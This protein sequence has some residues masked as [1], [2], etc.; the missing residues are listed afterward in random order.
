MVDS[1]EYAAAIKSIWC[2]RCTVNVKQDAQNAVGR[3]VQTEQTLF[4]DEPCRLSY[5][6]I[7]ITD[8][9]SQAARLEQQTVLIIDSALDIPPGS[10]ITVTHE[11]VTSDYE[12]SGAAAVY[13]VHQ[14]IPLQIKK[15]WA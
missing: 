15:E 8:E 9:S 5:K 13:S 6:S 7:N 14:E 2:D 10:K 4:A 1:K 12:R 3:T 11:G